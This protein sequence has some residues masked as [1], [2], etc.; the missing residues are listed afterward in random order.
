LS[1]RCGGEAWSSLPAA[2]LNGRLRPLFA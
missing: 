1:G 2:G